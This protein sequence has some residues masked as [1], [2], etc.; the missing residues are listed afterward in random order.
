MTKLN[1]EFNLH[2]G[3]EVEVVAT[4]IDGGIE[5]R[6][7]QIF[8]ITKIEKN[9]LKSDDGQADI[10]KVYL[11]GGP[12][13]CIYDFILFEYFK[14]R[15]HEMTNLTNLNEKMKALMNDPSFLEKFAA[16]IED[17]ENTRSAAEVCDDEYSKVV[18]VNF[19]ELNEQELA[20]KDHDLPT[21][22]IEAVDADGNIVR[23]G[24]LTPFRAYRFQVSGTVDGRWDHGSSPVC[25]LSELARMSDG[26][27]VLLPHAFIAIARWARAYKL[28]LDPYA[29]FG[30]GNVAEKWLEAT[31]EW[32]KTN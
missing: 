26:Y 10:S 15:R 13:C 23:N 18:G 32:L 19:R 3:Q 27:G 12:R 11:S 31:V 21:I 17:Y 6:Q 29:I 22:V 7:G 20:K 1:N 25:D 14:P 5:Y 4:F 24:Y 16:I 2:V 30:Y 8:S 28:G 9:V